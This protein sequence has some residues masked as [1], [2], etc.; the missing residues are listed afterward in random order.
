MTAMT[1]DQLRHDIVHGDQETRYRAWNRTGEVGAGAIVPLAELVGHEDRMV[2]LSAR[3]GIQTLVYHAG[4]PGA[5]AERVAVCAE[6]AKLLDAHY[7]LDLR[8]DAAAW[9]GA[10]GGDEA[11]DA[12]NPYLWHDQALR[13]DA[14]LAIE[15]ILG[16]K[17]VAALRDYLDHA[18]ETY[19]PRIAQSLRQRGV[20]VR[21]PKDDFWVL[22]S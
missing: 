10:L 4:R 21:R 11:V 13:E 7:P 8:A 19:R 20:R 5:E 14:R 22:P 16:D 2:G 9:L 17:A 15:R 18:P 3:R 1:L 12:L 6:L